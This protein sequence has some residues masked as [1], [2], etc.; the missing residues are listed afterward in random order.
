MKKI[1]L[2]AV[3]G[4]NL[5]A[6]TLTYKQ[7][8]KIISVEVVKKSE[9]YMI[10]DTINNGRFTGKKI[11]LKVK[12]I[13]PDFM[14]TIELQYGLIFTKVLTTGEFIYLL[15]N[16]SMDIFTVCSELSQNANIITIKPLIQIPMQMY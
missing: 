11:L 13:T 16:N 10:G 12:E 15:D 14:N 3:L 7:D 5:M 6:S 4:L 2:L 1:I 8:E 9:Y